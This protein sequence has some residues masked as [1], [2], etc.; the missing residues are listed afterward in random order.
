[1]L[2]AEACESAASPHAAGYKS[3]K[4]GVLCSGYWYALHM[5]PSHAY[6]V[7]ECRPL[8][9]SSRIAVP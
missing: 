1:M 6:G 8:L 3:I 5:L 4:F 2:L 9:P 7:L